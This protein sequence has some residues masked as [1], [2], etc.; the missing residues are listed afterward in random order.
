M[1]KNIAEVY[2]EHLVLLKP[3][4]GEIRKHVKKGDIVIDLGCGTG[5]YINTLEKQ[6]GRNGTIIGIDKR[7]E[8]VRYCKKKFQKPNFIFKQLPAEKLSLIKRKADVVLASLVLQFTNTK[9]SISGI[10]SILKP[11]GKLIMAIPL[12]RTGIEIAPDRESR[13]FKV[14]FLKNIKAGLKKHKIKKE[15]NFSYANKREKIFRE[16]LKKNGFVILSWK[17]KAL[18]KANL[19]VLLDYF[20]IGWRSERILKAPFSLRYT[21]LTSALKNTFAK[22]PNFKVNRYYLIAVANKK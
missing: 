21:V 9:K 12:Y 22:Y 5:A 13:I 17:I 4:I 6:I 14:E 10:R 2:N 18:V 16:L 7:A 11:N 8:M 20:K 3:L 15:P 1:K 19:G